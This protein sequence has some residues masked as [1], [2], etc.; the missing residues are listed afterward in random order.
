MDRWDRWATALLVDLLVDHFSNPLPAKSKHLNETMV[1]CREFPHSIGTIFKGCLI[2]MGDGII[3]WNSWV[4]SPKWWLH[5]IFWCQ[6]TIPRWRCPRWRC[7]E[8]SVM[9]SADGYRYKRITWYRLIDWYIDVCW[10]LFIMFIMF[11]VFW[12]LLYKFLKGWFGST[13]N[14]IQSCLLVP[15]GPHKNLETFPGWR[16]LVD[17]SMISTSRFTWDLLSFNIIKS[18]KSIQCE[19]KF[20]D[21]YGGIVSKFGPPP[22]HP[23]LKTYF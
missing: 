10:C 7:S 19:S 22:C 18:W 1:F 16:G 2:W 13:A 21:H 23:I 4:I 3:W 14:R 12:Y 11:T 8:A 9:G 5:P 15:N 20:T 6:D 17:F